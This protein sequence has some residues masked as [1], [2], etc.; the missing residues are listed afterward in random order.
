MAETID[1]DCPECGY[2]NYKIVPELSDYLGTSS[3]VDNPP[4]DYKRL[5]VAC[6]QHGC[7]YQYHI[8]LKE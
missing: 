8:Y 2:S 3:T 5:P 4:E 6:Q 1:H 7:D